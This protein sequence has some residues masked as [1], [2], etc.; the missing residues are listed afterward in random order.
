MKMLGK[1]CL[2]QSFTHVSSEIFNLLDARPAE[3]IIISKLLHRWCHL[4]LGGAS[5]AS[6]AHPSSDG[7]AATEGVSERKLPDEQEAQV[8]GPDEGAE[9]EQQ[10]A[11]GD[12][13]FI[14]QG[15]GPD[16]Q[17]MHPMIQIGMGYPPPYPPMFMPPMAMIDPMTGMMLLPPPPHPMMMMPPFPPF[18]MMPPMHPLPAGF[19][20]AGMHMVA[21]G[22]GFAPPAEGPGLTPSPNEI[23]KAK[24]EA[25]MRAQLALQEEEEIREAAAAGRDSAA[26]SLPDLTAEL[27]PEK[28][29]AKS[30]GSG[31]AALMKAATSGA[32]IADETKAGASGGAS[33]PVDTT[34]EGAALSSVGISAGG[35]MAGAFP[36]PVAPP[37][38][39]M[40]MAMNMGMPMGGGVAPQQQPPT[41]ATPM[42]PGKPGPT[43][44]GQGQGQYGKVKVM[45]RNSNTSP[46]KSHNTTMPPSSSAAAVATSMQPPP[47]QGT[48]GGS[49]PAKSSTTPTPIP[50]AKTSLA[51]ITKAKKSAVA[52]AT[53][54][55]LAAA[56]ALPAVPVSA[57]TT[58]TGDAPGKEKD[59]KPL[60]LAEKLL[61]A[62][63]AL[64]E[65]SQQQ[66]QGT[67]TETVITTTAASVSGTAAVAVVAAAVE[68][69]QP[70]ATADAS[71]ASST[72][73]FSSAGSAL[74]KMLG[75][76]SSSNNSTGD[77][78]ETK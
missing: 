75:G 44:Q 23:I 22:A 4:L 5:A 32:A 28:A 50:T 34:V 21:P 9:H 29:S 76:G 30:D 38:N 65:R 36:M 61:R 26:P 64:Q 47:N 71:V 69:K 49:K 53:T 73:F 74:M 3:K 25:K 43:G 16:G 78:S 59:E 51:P 67:G 45:S 11:S 17:P 12:A 8:Q 63:Q 57:A 10:Q 48:K 20:Q 72:G 39:M 1:Y 40:A 6:A 2:S 70:V 68:I 77:G 14:G 56:V 42:G 35:Y 55:K 66:G 7:G 37:I 62:K 58:S 24:R 33:K 41:S 13:S 27:P 31:W 18:G 54:Q 15:P 46:S 19:Q 52:T 60:T